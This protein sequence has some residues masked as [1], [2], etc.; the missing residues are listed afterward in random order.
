[1]AQEMERKMSSSKSAQSAGGAGASAGGEST[2]KGGKK[3]KLVI[4]AIAALVLLGGGAGGAYT[5]MKPATAS[6]SEAVEEEVL[7]PGEVTALDPITINLADGR[8]LKLGIALQQVLSE[9]GGEGSSA[10]DGSKALD[11]AIRAFSGLTM[12]DLS[13]VES[14]QK[15]KDELQSQII[16]AYVAEPEKEGEEGLKQVMGIYFTQFVMQ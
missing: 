10:V 12:S 6:A 4:A 3:K 11:L 15:Y 13:N 1:M 7:V 16:E 14:R 8:Y 9:A 2:E 5:F